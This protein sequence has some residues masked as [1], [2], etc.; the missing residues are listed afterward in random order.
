MNELDQIYLKILYYGLVA[1]RNATGLGDLEWC[2][3]EA[4]HI[5]ELPTLI[6][7]ANMQR[8]LD[9]YCRIKTNYIEWIKTANREDVKEFPCRAY[10]PLWSRMHELL[11]IDEIIESGKWPDPPV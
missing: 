9:Y 7:E 4:Q 2:R 3:A 5:H 10:L 1:I 6:G 11:K 8:H